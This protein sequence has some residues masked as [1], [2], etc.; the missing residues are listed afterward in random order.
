MVVLSN[1]YLQ[2]LEKKAIELALTFDIATKTFHRYVDDSYAR[3]GS[4]NNATEFLNVLNSQDPQ[5]TIEYENDIKELN[6]LDVTIRNNLNHSYDF[7][8]YCKPAIT[9]VQI[10]PRSNICRNIA[11]GVFKGFLSSALHICSENYLAQEIEFLY[12]NV[13][14]ENGHSI[15]VLEKV[16]K[17]YMN[18]ISFVKEKVNIE[19]IKNDKI[20]KLPWVPNLGPKLRKEF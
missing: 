8:V 4:K 3:F 15:A 20:V 17:E 12:L 11:M 2:N 18:N 19:K 13:F 1:S 9:N 6:F 10:K 14:V 5:T 16:T 7:A